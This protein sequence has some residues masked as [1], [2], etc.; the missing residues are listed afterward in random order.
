[1]SCPDVSVWAAPAT[2]ASRRRQCNPVPL[3]HIPQRPLNA[4]GQSLARRMA[5]SLL[6]PMLATVAR[7]VVE[8]RLDDVLDLGA[9]FGTEHAETVDES[10]S[11]DG[12]QQ[13]ALDVAGVV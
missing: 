11:V 6:A 7:S 13:F 5:G 9:G 10:A 12:A 8:E 2:R 4:H 1:M 3:A